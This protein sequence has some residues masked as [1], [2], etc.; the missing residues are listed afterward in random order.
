MDDLIIR[1]AVLLSGN[2]EA[3]ARLWQLSLFCDR[4][5]K[6]VGS[7]AAWLCPDPCRLGSESALKRIHSKL[8]R[9][10]PLEGVP[11]LCDRLLVHE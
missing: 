6:E 2:K 4:L 9:S 1:Q 8:D 10:E 5:F 11:A 7:G 3:Q